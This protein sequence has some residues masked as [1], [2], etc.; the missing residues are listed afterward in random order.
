M[1]LSSSSKSAG[2][3]SNPAR[4]RML[5]PTSQ[6]EE[7]LFDV[8]RPLNMQS[9]NQTNQE[10]ETLQIITKDLI[11]TIRIPR[12][13]VS[14]P[15]IVLPPSEVKRIISECQTGVKEQREALKRAHRIEKEEK[16][17][18]AEVRK[19]QLQDVDLS[20]KQNPV[21]TDLQLEAQRRAELVVDRANALR[22]EQEEEVKRLNQLILGAQCQATWDDQIQEKKEIRALLEEEEKRLDDMMEVERRRALENSEKKD[23][24]HK[25]QMIKGKDQMIEQIQKR[26]EKKQLLEMAKEIEK[27]QIHKNREKMDLEDLKAR[28]KKRKEQQLLQE[29]I[30][31]IN[32]EVMQAKEKRLEQEKLDDT[33]AMEY[34]QKKLEREAEYEAEQKRIKKEKEL[35]IAQLR[36]QQ[37]R[38]KDLMAEQDE[39]RARRNQELADR[40]WRMKQRELAAEK[41]RVEATL[42]AARL[43][44]IKNK[45]HCL[46][47]E[48]NREK[49]V[50]ERVLKTQQEAMAKQKE[51]K[52]KQLQ[53]ALRHAESL[54]QQMKEQELSAIAQRRERFQEVNRLMEEDR[55]RRLRLIEVKEKKLKEL[56][57]TGISEKYCNEVERKVRKT[58]AQPNPVKV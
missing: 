57:A 6:V 1:K 35:E 54:R 36:A 22:M 55:Q 4:Y 10:Q 50:L 7:T 43:E 56:K 24:R 21:L 25:Q 44:Q 46:C 14:R 5:A 58:L 29:E 15:S 30:M 38:A 31:R 20:G 40:Q 12:R 28:E 47:L 9:N 37:E 41:A 2:S 39:V 3:R 45:E 8:P 53:K 13:E 27:E 11:R 49:R 52:E 17:K 42:K 34:L 16:T 26:M 19:L 48:A 32:A 51:L 23:E 33:R 18:A